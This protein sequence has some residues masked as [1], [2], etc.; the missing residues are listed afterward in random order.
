MELYS[1]VSFVPIL[2]TSWA[3]ATIFAIFSSLALWSRK[4]YQIIENADVAMSDL[5]GQGVVVH[6]QIISKPSNTMAM[7]GLAALGLMIAAILSKK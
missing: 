2:K 7:L 6:P 4:P 1:D 5:E 3:S